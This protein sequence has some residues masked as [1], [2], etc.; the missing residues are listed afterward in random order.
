MEPVGAGHIH[1]VCCRPSV[2]Q[3]TRAHRY[4]V[5]NLRHAIVVTASRKLWGSRQGSQHQ[6]NSCLPPHLEKI[7][8]RPGRMVDVQPSYMN[9]TQHKKVSAR[10]VATKQQTHS[11]EKGPTLVSISTTGAVMSVHGLLAL[12]D[13]GRNS[14]SEGLYVVGRREESTRTSRLTVDASHCM[15]LYLCGCASGTWVAS[16]DFAHVSVITR[17][18]L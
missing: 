7:R 16:D 12:T 15:T 14:C 8:T 11:T 3:P 1:T 2:R 9:T 5:E 13:T 17:T 10:P 4:P 18:N 6:H